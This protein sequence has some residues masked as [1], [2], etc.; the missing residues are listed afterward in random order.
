MSKK[1]FGKEIENIVG[2]GHKG[3]QHKS[4]T[5]DSL[6]ESG[7]VIKKGWLV[8]VDFGVES[9]TFSNPLS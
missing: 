2:E 7:E 8:I 9:K 1:F 6:R 3:S 4:K 5:K